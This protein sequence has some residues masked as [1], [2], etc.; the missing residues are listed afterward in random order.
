MT[1]AEEQG[2]AVDRNLI[3]WRLDTID[4]KIGLANKETAAHREALMAKLDEISG[5]N[6][7]YK[8]AMESRVAKLETSV[9]T[10]NALT[11]G[12]AT[13]FGAAGAW[14]ARHYGL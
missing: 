12:V 14:L 11:A 13:L 5:K 1:T 8:T 9:S 10:R 6:A 3:F 2:Y 7:D 4:E